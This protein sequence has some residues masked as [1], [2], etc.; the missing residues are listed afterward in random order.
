MNCHCHCFALFPSCLLLACVG[1]D[2]LG[3]MDAL[4]QHSSLES[5]NCYFFEILG[6]FDCG[7]YHL[8]LF[9]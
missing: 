9:T 1:D 2:I 8:I 6:F 5:E 3:E 7:F 4:I